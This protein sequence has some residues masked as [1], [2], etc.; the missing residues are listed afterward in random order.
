MAEVRL[1][2]AKIFDKTGLAMSDHTHSKSNVILLPGMKINGKTQIREITRHVSQS[3]P[4]AIIIF[5]RL[6]FC[7]IL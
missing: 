3:R 6:L 4:V 1:M 5:K 2:M 7:D